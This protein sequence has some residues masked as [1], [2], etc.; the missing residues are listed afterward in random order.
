MIP[1]TRHEIRSYLI[2][3]DFIYNQHSSEEWGKLLQEF[4]TF[5]HETNAQREG[6]KNE[7]DRKKQEVIK[8]EAELNRIKSEKE[9]VKHELVIKDEK[10]SKAKGGLF[11]LI[12]K[13]YFKNA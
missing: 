12:G 4:K 7:L 1:K 8:L 3:S 11:G 9:K 6:L 5:W 2:T 13:I 10:I